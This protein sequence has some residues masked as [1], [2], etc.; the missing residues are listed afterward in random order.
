MKEVNGYD[1][2]KFKVKEGKEAFKENT[3]L[4]MFICS[5]ILCG[6]PEAT[7]APSEIPGTT[8]DSL[9]KL[10]S[11]DS[12]DVTVEENLT[13]S[14]GDTYSDVLLFN[15]DVSARAVYSLNGQYKRMTATMV[16]GEK[17]VLGQELIVWNFC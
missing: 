17:T 12:H 11:I 10:H 7:E 8:S 14:Y 3:F 1:K 16:S 13:D 2:E 9:T 5:I 15:A 4:M 6:S